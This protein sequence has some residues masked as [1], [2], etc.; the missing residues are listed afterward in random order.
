MFFPNEDVE[1]YGIFLSHANPVS[2]RENIGKTIF[3]II[4]IVFF[5]V[6][7]MFLQFC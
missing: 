3:L 5:Q 1:R 4:L 6:I 7:E 2:H